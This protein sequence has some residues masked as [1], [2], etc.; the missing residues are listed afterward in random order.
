MAPC[1]SEE[2]HPI[3][4]QSSYLPKFVNMVTIKSYIFLELQANLLWLILL[5]LLLATKQTR[6]PNNI[7]KNT[8][9]KARVLVFTA[10][11]VV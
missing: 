9:S 3:I 7:V 10:I 2:S 8:P 11:N 1:I 4:Y 5:L 6:G